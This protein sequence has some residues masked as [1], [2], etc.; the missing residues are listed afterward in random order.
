MSL[1]ELPWNVFQEK[2]CASCWPVFLPA[3]GKIHEAAGWS[4][5]SHLGPQNRSQI[6]GAWV[7][8]TS[9][10]YPKLP[11]AGALLQ[12]REMDLSLVWVYFPTCLSLGFPKADPKTRIW[13]KVVYLGEDV[14]KHSRAERNETGK[15]A[16]PIKDVIMSR[17][18]LR[19]TEAPSRRG[20][21]G[22]LC[23]TGT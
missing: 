1:M 3:I 6:E 20:T 17:L 15:G 9:W 7:S 11:S 2:E 8:M 23:A 19:A 16:K 5:W 12:D 10:G 14:R 21:C 22:R 13:V 4:W 18:L